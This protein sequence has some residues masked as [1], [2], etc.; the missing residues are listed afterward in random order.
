MPQARRTCSESISIDLL[1]M[2]R[3]MLIALLLLVAA[4]LLWFGAPN[5][6]QA[7]QPYSNQSSNFDG[8][9]H[10]SSPL[11]PSKPTL[12]IQEQPEQRAPDKPDLGESS[13][14]EALPNRASTLTDIEDGL[15]LLEDYTQRTPEVSE[16]IKSLVEAAKLH[17][18]KA[19]EAMASAADFDEQTRSAPAKIATLEKKLASNDFEVELPFN[20]QTSIAKLPPLDQLQTYLVTKQDALQQ[21]LKPIENLTAAELR[22]R[23]SSIKTKA[24]AT[25]TKL[26]E[27]ERQIQ[28]APLSEDE[29][30]IQARRWS[31]EAEQLHLNASLQSG[32]SEIR[33]H[34]AASDLPELQNAVAQKQAA[35]LEKAI[36]ITENEINRIRSQEIQN[37]KLQSHSRQ[38]TTSPPLKAIAQSNTALT[39]ELSTIAN[40]IKTLGDAKDAIEQDTLR[41][42]REE[43]TTKT[44]IKVVGLSDSFGQMLQRNRAGLAE[45][46]QRHVPIN[47]R[48][49]QIADSQI[50]I[51][52]WEDELAK[53][54][55][56]PAATT[57]TVKRLVAQTPT[58]SIA[59]SQSNQD[60]QDEVHDLLTLRKDILT[61]LKRL[62]KQRNQTLVALEIE[63]NKLTDACKNY[64]SLIDENI[65]W[66]RSV[67]VASLSDARVISDVLENLVQPS[68]WNGVW[69][70]IMYSFRSRF[71]L[72]TLMTLVVVALFLSRGTVIASA[73]LDGE[74]AIK[75]SCR[76][77]GITLT[78][79]VRTLALATAVLSPL[80]L[81]GWLLTNN[82]ESTRFAVSLGKTCYWTF[83]IGLP[84][85]FLR[86]T[87]RMDGLAHSHFAWTERTRTVLWNNLSWL[88]PI[89]LPLIA[90][91]TW[92]PIVGINYTMAA[93]DE[94]DVTAIALLAPPAAL[95]FSSTTSSIEKAPVGNLSSTFQFS[96]G[97]AWNRL[98][99]VVLSIL[100]LVCLIFTCRTL[101]PNQGIL[102]DSRSTVFSQTIW[103]RIGYALFVSAI[104][105]PLVLML[106]AIV[107]YYFSSIQIGKSL[108]KTI[109]L[110]IGVAVVYSGAMRFLLV[111]RRHLRYEQ[112]VHQ[113]NQARLALEKKGGPDATSSPAEIIDIDLQ[114]DPG[115]DITDVSRQARELTNVIFLMI[116]AIILWGIWQYL[117][118]ASK[119]MDEW[120]LWPISIGGKIESVTI[121]DVLFSAITFLV[122]YFG[123]RNIPGMLEL[124]LLQK[125]PL[126]AGAR[127]AVTTIFRYLLL[128]VG[129]IFALGYLKIPWSNYSWLVAAISVGLG[130]GLQE[131]VANFVSGLILL[132]ERPVRVGDVVTIDDTTG[133]VSRIQMRATTVTNWDNQELVVPNKDLISGKLLNWTLSSVVNRI[134]LKFGVAYGTDPEA[135]QKIVVDAISSNR[136][137][138]KEPPP[139]VTFEEFGDSSLN[140]TLR[141]C[142]STIE[143]RWIIVHELNV[144]INRALA[145]ENISIPFPQRDVHLIPA[146]S[147]S[148]TDV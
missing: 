147:N 114:N 117:L 37:L 38:Q 148:Q 65:L 91:L 23:I 18:S 10:V 3:E 84:F 90:L 82:L 135:V 26:A 104:V 51:F 69:H 97:N 6:S 109:A 74:K 4:S 71:L 107:G 49:Q 130:F 144:A 46:Q 87:C 111:R 24:T 43:M 15:K 52:R 25:A 39:Q 29:Q 50:A 118:P 34:E 54:S 122:T 33:F 1:I 120:E 80:I 127:Y 95:D 73:R 66:V 8:F 140:F 81:L 2:A 103:L 77:F 17:L 134:A 115:L 13:P 67:P 126:D 44:R 30:F 19:R 100:L 110:V 94:V 48:N 132:L 125:L 62:E 45:T 11:R 27:I 101:H 139:V 102:I 146:E 145:A 79:Y 96:G 124:L 12:R 59:P 108:L 136:A 14:A 56:L 99:R 16:E 92:L 53:L 78:T 89:G 5:V 138:L 35:E 93:E 32:D 98:G 76:D 106:M 83:L 137:L 63:Q 142:V 7:Q 116:S 112:L 129:C 40:E 123:V 143:R 9:R 75:R 70:A 105:I 55:D 61:R 31:L 113:R 131:I 21:A 141:C 22:E 36:G 60:L 86:Q 72:S 88:I 57:A 47:Q 121:R 58:D 128:M 119:I 42:N 41:V 20:E 68:R 85:E 133:V 64:A 28:T